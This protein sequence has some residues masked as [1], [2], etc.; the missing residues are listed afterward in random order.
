[1][2]QSWP[3]FSYKRSAKAEEDNSKHIKVIKSA[4]LKQDNKHYKVVVDMDGSLANKDEEKRDGHIKLDED[5]SIDN[6]IGDRSHGKEKPTSS[7]A[8]V[9]KVLLV[10][11]FFLSIVLYKVFETQPP[12]EEGPE[13]WL[14]LKAVQSKCENN[15]WYAN[16][17]LNCTNLYNPSGFPNGTY[18][19]QGLT[20]IKILIMTCI[21]SAIDGGIGFVLPRIAVRSKTNIS[22]FDNHDNI[23]IFFDVVHLKRTLFEACPQLPILGNDSPADHVIQAAFTH[24]LALYEVDA[25]RRH[26]DTLLKQYNYRE[27]GIVSIWEETLLFNWNFA[28]DN[29]RISAFF[30]N[31]LIIF[32]ENIRAVSASLRELLQDDYIGFHLRI[33]SDM[34]CYTYEEMVNWFLQTC[35]DKNLFSTTKTIYVAVGDK[36]IEERFFND[37]QR[38]G[39]T[40]ISKSSVAQR[41]MTVVEKIKNLTFDQVAALDYDIL[42]NSTH[43]F[44]SGRTSFGYSIAYERG[45]ENLNF[46]NCSLYEF[47]FDG[48][49]C[50]S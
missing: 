40:A 22:L 17:Y 35:E 6:S 3:L 24:T 12:K 15:K 39:F 49:L 4:N 21:R 37:M 44:G 5:D 45:N 29:P 2:K 25:Y 48:L 27:G 31:K 26:V 23:D 28:K 16:V 41:N 19:Q 10:L 38:R 47:I 30:H 36:N 18:Q 8:T 42:L 20:N 33:E 46:C 32:N 11:I 43:F 14:N 1:M 34:D 50:C 9:F 7:K 13:E